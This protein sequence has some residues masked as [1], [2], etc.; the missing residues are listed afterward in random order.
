[1]I[2][3]TLG[4]PLGGTTV[5]GHQGFESL[6]SSLMTPPNFGGGGGSCLPSIVMVALGEPGTPVICCAI[7]GTATRMIAMIK[8]TIVH[9]ADFIFILLSL[10]GCGYFPSSGSPG[11]RLTQ[12]LHQQRFVVDHF[13]DHV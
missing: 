8:I 12:T 13:D 7:A 5:G 1:M 9:T 4:A 11:W 3:S 10:S 6:A 2:K